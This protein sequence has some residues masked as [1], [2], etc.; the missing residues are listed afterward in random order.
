MTSAIPISTGKVVDLSYLVGR[1][2]SKR[3]FCFCNFY[4][5]VFIFLIRFQIEDFFESFI[6][7]LVEN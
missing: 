4:N 2:D 5:N 3:S 1:L 6:L 7:F